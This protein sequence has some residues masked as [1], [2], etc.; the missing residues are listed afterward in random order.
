MVGTMPWTKRSDAPPGYVTV[1]CSL[2]AVLL[3]AGDVVRVDLTWLPSA[4]GL[5]TV[6]KAELT[7]GLSG[8]SLSLSEY[9]DDI[10][11]GWVPEADEQPFEIAP[12]EV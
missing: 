10:E 1:A 2:E 8:V 12:A 4:T 5:Y 3:E 6:E 11:N 7:E 9:S